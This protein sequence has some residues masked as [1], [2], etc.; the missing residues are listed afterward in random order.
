MTAELAR[1]IIE[2]NSYLTLGTADAD[3]RP[4]A[5]P[6]WF[7]HDRFTD[8]VW[9]SRPGTRHS[10][11]IAVRPD[12]GIVVFDSTVPIGQGQAVYAEAVAA[13][14]P[15]ASAEAAIALFSARSVAQGGHTWSVADVAGP[16]QFRLYRARATAHYVLDGRDSRVLVSP[17]V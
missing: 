11:N 4:W 13:E 15:E 6:V 9:V 2:A 7:A 5:N 14:I 12:V 1:Q 10:R 3:G 8:F 17:G 16:A